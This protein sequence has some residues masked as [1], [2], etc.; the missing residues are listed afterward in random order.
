MS[1]SSVCG[2]D[3]SVASHS[4]TVLSSE[5][6]ASL[7]EGDAA[8]AVGYRWCC[9]QAAGEG[10]VDFAAVGASFEVESGSVGERSSGPTPSCNIFSL[11]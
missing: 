4:L 3:P 1:T 9:G 2:G 11:T 5:L 7:A 6:D 10:V 8:A